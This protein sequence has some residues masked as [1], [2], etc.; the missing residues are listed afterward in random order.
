MSSEK[1]ILLRV[2]EID[3]REVAKGIARVSTNVLDYL[4][5]SVG[6]AVV[7]MGSK[8]EKRRTGAMCMPMPATKAWEKD[9]IKLDSLSR[10]NA[11]AFVG[12]S[13]MVK[14]ARPVP[15]KQVT[16][17]P[18]EKT[19]LS[20]LLSNIN[21]YTKRVIFADFD[22][23]YVSKGDVI[24]PRYYAGGIMIAVEA[25]EPKMAKQDEAWLP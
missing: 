8:R 4:G 12:Y 23:S 9:A 17:K 13:V 19:S 11:G 24:Y 25:I 3:P 2:E 20:A 22:S 6:D 7:I 16:L 14:K 5:A 15:A 10:N 18:M 21:G 1:D